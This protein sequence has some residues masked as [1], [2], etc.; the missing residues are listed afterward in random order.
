[1]AVAFCHHRP[2]MP[3]A[4]KP[5]TDGPA[6]ARVAVFERNALLREMLTEIIPALGPY[7]LSMVT[8]DADAFVA[9]LKSDPAIRIAVLGVVGDEDAGCALLLRIRKECPAVGNLVL[10]STPQ[11]ASTDRAVNGGAAGVLCNTACSKELGKALAKLSVPGGTY[12]DHLVRELYRPASKGGGE[13]ALEGPRISDAE[14]RVLRA[15]LKP[16]GA[17]DKELAQLL[18]LEVPTVRTHLRH[19]SKAFDVRGRQAL[20]DTAR[21]LGYHLL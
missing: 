15:L 11:R 13:K 2:H 8:E 12:F 19:L 1:M 20:I 6:T 5:D 18:D 3:M 21:S 7:T 4:S 17:A 14:M 10:G 9:H 16:G